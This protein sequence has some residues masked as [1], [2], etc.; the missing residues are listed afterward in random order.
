MEGFT[1]REELSSDL[2]RATSEDGVHVLV[3]FPK[4]SSI[5]ALALCRREYEMGCKLKDVRGVHAPLQVL[6]GNDLVG[7]LYEDCGGELFSNHLSSF[8]ARMAVDC[9]ATLLDFL[10]IAINCMYIIFY[11]I[12]GA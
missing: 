5:S 6:E 4:D 12:F 9:H 10:D 3:K 2:W 7:L 8:C 1:L 11:F